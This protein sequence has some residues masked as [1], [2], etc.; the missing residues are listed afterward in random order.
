MALPLNLAISKIGPESDPLLQNLA[1]HY[2]HDMSEWF[3]VD[4]CDDGRY[5]YDT[6]SVWAN[7]YDVYLAR[8]DGAIAGFAIVG[9]AREWLGETGARDIHE[10]FVLRKFRRRGVGRSFARFVWAEHPGGWLVRVLEA[11]EPALEFWRNEISVFAVGSFE[12]SR[13]SKNGR[14]WRFLRFRVSTRCRV[15]R[16]G[17]RVFGYDEMGGDKHGAAVGFAINTQFKRALGNAKLVARLGKLGC[18]ERTFGVFGVEVFDSGFVDG[19]IWFFDF[20]GAHRFT[21]HS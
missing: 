15:P 5:C 8:V 20:G 1:Q 11:N 19:F 18:V 17:G 10:F 2:C 6:A 4:V 14:W 9:S 16:Q 7:G 12:E 3:D 13:Q 21:S